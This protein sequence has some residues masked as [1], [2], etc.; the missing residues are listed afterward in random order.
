[1]ATYDIGDQPVIT[2]TFT[3]DGEPTS[4]TTVVAFVLKPD[5]TEDELTPAEASEG[6]YVTTLPVLDADGVWSWRVKG[7]AGV[8]AADEDT[9]RVDR[10]RFA[11]P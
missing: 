3:V 9:F 4:P 6:V 8:I 10:S 5:G 11:T 2:T 7:T 1:M